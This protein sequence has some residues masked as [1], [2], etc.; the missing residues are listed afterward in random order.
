MKKKYHSESQLTQKLNFT[1]GDADKCLACESPRPGAKISSNASGGSV[2][3]P[4]TEKV[5]APPMDDLFAKFTKKAAGNWICDV[6]MLSN[7]GIHQLHSS[8]NL[9]CCLFPSISV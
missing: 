7:P 4:K 2:S 1:L 8:L 3:E 5:V 6:C 9:L